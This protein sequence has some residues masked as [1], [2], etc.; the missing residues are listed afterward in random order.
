MTVAVALAPAPADLN[1]L[2]GLADCYSF[3]KDDSS[4]DSSMER[5]VYYTTT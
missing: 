2:R 1:V 4:A 5:V 3:L